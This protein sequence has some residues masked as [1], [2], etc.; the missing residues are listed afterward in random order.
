[1]PFGLDDA[2]LGWLVGSASD[3]AVRRL[4]SDSAKKAMRQVVKEAVR[5]T[6]D[7]CAD[8]LDGEQAEHLRSV[9]SERDAQVSHTTASSLA[10]LRTALDS[11]TAALD[12]P[13]FDQPGY[14]AGLG[15][16]AG[17]LSEELANRIASGIR[18][19]GRA[20][21]P[22]KPLAEWL[23]RDQLTVDVGQIKQDL[24]HLVVEP[25]KPR[26][27]G[28]PGGTP[29]FTGRRQVL[30]ELAERVKA[31][32]P[33]GTVV[34]IHSIDGMAGV[35]KT[36]LALRAA[37]QHKHHYPD[38]QYFINLHGYTE[39]IPP[40][41]PEAALEELLRQAGEP[42]QAIPPNLASRQAR[43]QALMARQRA[44]VLLDNVLDI[45]QVRPLLPNSAG[46]LVLI[47]SRSRLTGLPG[48][49]SLP[50]NVLS[51]PEAIE[52][53]TRLVATDR[54]P[55]GNAVAR[56]VELVGHL[57]VA[58]EAVAGQIHDEL[59]VAELTDDLADAKARNVLVDETSQPGAGV[60]AAFETSIQRLDETHRRALRLLGLY[61]G[62]SIGVPQFAAL[63]DMPAA[64]ARTV[65]RTLTDR[66]LIKPSRSRAG[67]R[68]YELHDLVREFAGEQAE[69]HMS[70][71]R[72]DAVARLTTWYATALD[73]VAQLWDATDPEP[74]TESTVDGLR[75]NA[76]GEARAWLAAEQDNLVAFAGI[77]TGTEAA[78]V[79]KK[80]GVVAFC[81]E[82]TCARARA[83]P[84]GWRNL[85]A[86][87]RS[88]RGGRCAGWPGR[89]C[90]G[91]R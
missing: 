30:A 45:A 26:G 47:T 71:E 31:H 27:G 16:T 66:N 12:H 4:R 59:T 88:G 34:A 17:R 55:D 23:W 41:S 15:L 78:G 57:P 11:W 36:E 68:R 20:G 56:A 42:A 13:E 53:F 84:V 73:V 38:G 18:E 6:V 69:S 54:C 82:S 63:A 91:H 40:V 50:L 74:M 33:A 21:G 60:R 46:C 86:G 28:L 65:L 1:M 25:P 8:G 90:S 7:D 64:H 70:E 32:D 48:A 9:L 89:R 79:C 58:I 22:L 85:P 2:L 80:V 75:L 44:L 83:L 35:G 29:E 24:S 62:P 87:R 76:P 19:N 81:P 14:L 43:W 61:P 37:H 39:G 51:P 3:A 10:E 5:A 49:R 72:P 77:A 67:H 52:M